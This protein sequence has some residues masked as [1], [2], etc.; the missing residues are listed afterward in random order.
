MACLPSRLRNT[1][2]Q[3]TGRDWWYVGPDNGHISLYSREAFDYAFKELGGKERLMWRG[4]P[5]VQ[6]W[7]F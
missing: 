5:G 4:Y 1:T 7:Q 2:L 3:V 6:A